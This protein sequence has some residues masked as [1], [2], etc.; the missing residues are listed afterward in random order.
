VIADNGINRWITQSILLKHSN[1]NYK[2][3]WSPSWTGWY[4]VQYTTVSNDYIHAW[5][6]YVL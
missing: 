6:S 4:I 3:P 5:T 1:F 2:M